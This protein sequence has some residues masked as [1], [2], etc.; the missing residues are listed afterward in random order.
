MQIQVEDKLLRNRLLNVAAK[1]NSNHDNSL[2]AF[3]LLVERFQG[4]ILNLMWEFLINSNKENRKLSSKIDLEWAAKCHG[5]YHLFSD[6][7][8]CVKYYVRHSDFSL[9]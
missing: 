4:L 6:Y 1:Q 3:N 7:V 2:K 5:L 8:L 9:R